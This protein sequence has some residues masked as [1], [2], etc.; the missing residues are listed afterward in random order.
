MQGA[1][2]KVLL[3]V[4][5]I[6][7]LA[8]WVPACRLKLMIGNHLNYLQGFLWA[9]RVFFWKYVIFMALNYEREFYTYNQNLSAATKK[10]FCKA[11]FRKTIYHLPSAARSREL[12]QY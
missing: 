6:L 11:H 12:S 2:D 4:Y 8:L 10:Y 7:D 5:K 3:K 1:T 9:S